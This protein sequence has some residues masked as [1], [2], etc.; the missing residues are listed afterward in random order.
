MQLECKGQW[1]CIMEACFLDLHKKSA[2]I[3][4]ALNRG[5]R[6]TVL[7]HGKPA[8]IMERID[9]PSKTAPGTASQHAVFGIWADRQNGAPVDKRMK[10]QR[11]RRFDAL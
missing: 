2:E 5:E 11:R 4:K 8:A 1:A 6:V 7:N 10:K 9:G 3:I